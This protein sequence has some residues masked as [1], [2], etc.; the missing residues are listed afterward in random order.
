MT[1]EWRPAGWGSQAGEA[2][3]KGLPRAQVVAGGM[4]RGP[5][6]AG[7]TDSLLSARRPGDEHPC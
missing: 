2:R 1:L 7:V 3:R 5:E 4:H 6:E